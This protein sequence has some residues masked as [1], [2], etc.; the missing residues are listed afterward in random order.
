MVSVTMVVI[1]EKTEGE[2]ESQMWVIGGVLC[3]WSPWWAQGWFANQGCNNQSAVMH[4]CALSHASSLVFVTYFVDWQSR[5][6]F[7]KSI[8]QPPLIYP[9]C[10]LPNI[11]LVLTPWLIL[12]IAL[13]LV[14][15]V[16]KGGQTLHVVNIMGNPWVLLA[17]PVP[18]NHP[19]PHGRYRFARRST[20]LYLWYIRTHT[21]G[22]LPAG[23]L[24]WA[25]KSGSCSQMYSYRA[26]CV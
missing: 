24:N 19:Y 25:M 26:G 5:A 11:P 22:G 10:L 16:I 23:L 1:D 13:A 6:T 14:N 17:V 7:I 8:V 15:L 9:N 21:C 3:V 12:P 2:Q 20:F 4:W 18:I